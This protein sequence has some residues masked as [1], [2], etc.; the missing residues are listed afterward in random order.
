MNEINLTHL[1]SKLINDYEKVHGRTRFEV[2]KMEDT[3]IFTK[4]NQKIL[5]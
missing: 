2:K 4:I 1:I 3:F 5:D